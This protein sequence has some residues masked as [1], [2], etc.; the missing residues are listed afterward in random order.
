MQGAD[1]G[2]GRPFHG[3]HEIGAGCCQGNCFFPGIRDGGYGQ[4]GAGRN[5][6]KALGCQGGTAG[7]TPGGIQGIPPFPGT[8]LTRNQ[9]KG[10]GQ[11]IPHSRVKIGLA[12]GCG[13]IPDPKAGT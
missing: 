5:I 7:L 8:G 3:L 1:M 11:V 12:F 2:G 13:Q 10:Q 6:F 4:E 9:V